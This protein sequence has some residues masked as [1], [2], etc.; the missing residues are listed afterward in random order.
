MKMSRFLTPSLF[1][2]WGYRKVN[3]S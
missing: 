2:R 1:E 3:I